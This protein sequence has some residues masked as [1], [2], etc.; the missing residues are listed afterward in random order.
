MRDDD[1]VTHYIDLVDGL[2]TGNSSRKWFRDK[3]TGAT[4]KLPPES[5]M[6]LPT[7]WEEYN[8]FQVAVAVHDEQGMP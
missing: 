2:H 5:I 8:A 4:K 3:L 1:D 6:K 7:L